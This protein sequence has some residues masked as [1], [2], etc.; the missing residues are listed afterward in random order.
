MGQNYNGIGP[1]DGRV[2]SIRLVG[3]SVCFSSSIL[4]FYPSFIVLPF[5]LSQIVSDVCVINNFV[6]N[7][8]FESSIY[9]ADISAMAIPEMATSD[10]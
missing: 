10:E 7:L 6:T 2:R 5:L 9:S 8:S 3:E 4:V 1:G